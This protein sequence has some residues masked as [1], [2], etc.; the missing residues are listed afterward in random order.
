MKYL[1]YCQVL[2]KLLL[3]SSGWH[4]NQAGH[5]KGS[6]SHKANLMGTLIG[7]TARQAADK[8]RTCWFLQSECSQPQAISWG[9]REASVPP[10]L[11]AVALQSLV[12]RLGG[13]KKGNGGKTLPWWWEWRQWTGRNRVEGARSACW[14][15]YLLEGCWQWP[16]GT[17]AGGWTLGVLHEPHTGLVLRP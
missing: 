16:A 13:R 10:L 1:V 12:E 14:H 5:E 4:T 6:Q 9:N 11:P 2:S 3:W 8:I 7:R 17:A 15:P